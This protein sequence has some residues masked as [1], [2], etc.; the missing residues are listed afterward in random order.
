MLIRSKVVGPAELLTS[1]LREIGGRSSGVAGSLGTLGA[2]LLLLG[3][4]EVLRVRILIL[5]PL[6]LP[7]A[8]LRK[9][10]ECEERETRPEWAVSPGWV[11]HA[12]LERAPINIIAVQLANSHGGILVGIHLNESKSAIGL[13]TRLHDITKVLEERDEI[14]LRGVRGEVANVA[15]GLPGRGLGDDHVEAVDAMSREMV[16]SER[17]SGRHAHLGHG[18]LLCDGGLALLIRPVTANRA[19]A[20]PLAV[21]GAQGLLGLRAVAEGNESI[22]TRATRLH[23]PHNPSLR[24]GTE[25]GEGLQ[26]HFIV[27]FIGQ[28][29]NEDVEVAGSV[30]LGRRVRLV[31]P[32]DAN[33]L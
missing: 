9:N 32:V 18:L 6:F 16:V 24:D 21:H 12:A 17:G 20:E 29:T 28:I 27:D 31:G 8:K 4:V 19:R 14:V 7:L 23:V 22:A 30:F 2:I 11:T 15:G 33:L 3:R 10:K 25:S 13:E 26:Q 5:T 1:I